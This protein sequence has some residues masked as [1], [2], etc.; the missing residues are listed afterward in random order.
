MSD[1]LGKWLTLPSSLTSSYAQRNTRLFA[2][3]RLDAQSSGVLS[4]RAA[5][6]YGR[7]LKAEMKGD[8]F[9]VLILCVNKDDRRIFL[10]L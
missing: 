6:K 4:L 10:G 1:W 9:R 8:E 2:A 3:R 5:E 7:G